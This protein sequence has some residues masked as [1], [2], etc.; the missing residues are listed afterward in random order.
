L[1]P[2]IKEVAK[3]AGVAQS[4]VSLVINKKRHV[5]PATRQRVLKAIK[6]LS[7]HP[8]RSA[9]VLAT[10]KTGNIGFILSDKHFYQAEPFYT[11]IFLGTE[12]ESRKYYYYVLLTTVGEKFNPRKFIPRFLIENN[13]DGVILTGKVSDSLIYYIADS[14]VPVML[15]DYFPKRSK[16]PSVLI[17]NLQGAYEAV[18]HL[19]RLGHRRIGFIGGSIDHPSINDRLKG[20][21]QALDEFGLPRTGSLVAKDQPDSSAA[22]GYKAATR[23]MKLSSPPTAIFA[24]NDTMAVGTIKAAREA[25]LGVPDD[26][27]VVG[28]DDIEVASHTHPPLTTMRVPKEE[29]GA[30]AVRKMV[31]IIESG[32][33]LSE[34]TIVAAELVVRGSCG[35]ENVQ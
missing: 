19:I 34:K 20:Y 16:F 13:V 12:L 18:V 17:D 15:I 11:R 10:R 2:T 23:L 24:T 14:G 4:T 29:M 9:R 31:E 8:R 5:S 25:G 27:A 26:L 7:Y 33:K 22:D 1:P 32:D 30:L 3:K 6:E 35:A 28:F 21:E